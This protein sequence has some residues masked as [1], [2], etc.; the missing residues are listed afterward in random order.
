MPSCYAILQ[1][2]IGYC[3]TYEEPSTVCSKTF[4]IPKTTCVRLITG[5]T[6]RATL[7]RLARRM[8]ELGM[9]SQVI[10]D[11][12]V[13]ECTLSKDN[14]DTFTPTVGQWHWVVTLKVEERLYT[15]RD[16]WVAF[17][18]MKTANRMKRKALLS[19]QQ[20]R[21]VRFKQGGRDVSFD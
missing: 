16:D 6:S 9:I 8:K 19:L 10:V 11:T 1:L 15:H 12:V 14:R 18:D 13:I 3:S 5:K 7:I 2:V 17:K 4:K 21:F 20:Q